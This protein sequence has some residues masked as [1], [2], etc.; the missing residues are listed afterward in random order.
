MPHQL[1]SVHWARHVESVP[2][3]DMMS[4]KVGCGS[5]SVTNPSSYEARS[6]GGYAFFLFFVLS[7]FLGVMRCL[8]VFGVIVEMLV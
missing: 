5:S 8:F 7:L 2:M 4:L 1:I 3:A 6:D